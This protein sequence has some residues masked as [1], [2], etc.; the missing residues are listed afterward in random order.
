MTAPFNISMLKPGDCLLYRPVDVFDWAVALK[1]WTRVSHVEVYIGDHKSVASR[2]GSGVG[3]YLVRLHDMA[4]VRR[5]GEG[6]NLEQA[7][8]WFDAVAEG[9]K[10]GWRTLLT[11]LLLNNSAI[12]GE[13]ICSEFA[14]EFYNAGGLPLFAKDWPSYRTPPSLEVAT[15]ELTTVWDDGKLFG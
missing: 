15:R 4:A 10:Y 3:E 9:Q 8:R 1:T 2:N 11:F 14:A 5:L 12:E 6:F 13:M 7:L